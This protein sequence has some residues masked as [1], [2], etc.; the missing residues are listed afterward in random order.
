LAFLQPASV[1]VAPVLAIAAALLPTT[2]TP[3]LTRAAALTV[4][5][6]N[7]PRTQAIQRA[8]TDGSST[9]CHRAVLRAIDNARRAEGRKPLKL[10]PY[11]FRLTVP[12]Q[13]LVIAHLERVDRGLPGFTGLSAKLD[14]L[15]L[16]GALSNTLP[17]GPAAAAWGSNWADGEGSA[18]LADFDWMYNDG[19]GSPN[20]ECT[21]T[22]VTG[23]WGHRL[24]ILGHYGPRPS[25]G[26]AVAKVDGVTSVTELFSSSPAGRL[27][28]RLPK[29]ATVSPQAR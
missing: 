29:A 23:C 24:N 1:V 22:N 20:V 26:A 27:H 12:Q 6:E 19:P 11:Y 2:I 16:E 28:Y 5:T 3:Q 18:L 15:A 13:L 14:L 9:A 4:P 17:T 21:P 25:M 10:P 8:C 7:T